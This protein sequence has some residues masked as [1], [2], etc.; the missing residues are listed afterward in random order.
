MS[1]PDAADSEAAS[2]D[3]NREPEEL[4]SIPESLHTNGGLK[5][6]VVWTISSLIAASARH[7]LLQPIIADHEMLD[8]LNLTDADGQGVLTMDKKQLQELRV[9]PVSVS[10]NSHRTLMPALIMRLWYAPHIELPGG[11]LLK[12][13]PRWWRS[14]QVTMC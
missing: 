14:D 11:V 2:L 4:A 7:Y 6:R 3:D 5:L 1:S 9:R 8:S 10:G 12:G 13:A